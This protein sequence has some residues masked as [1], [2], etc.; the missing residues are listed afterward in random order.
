MNSSFRLSGRLYTLF[1]SIALT[2]VLSLISL[3]GVASKPGYHDDIDRSVAAWHMDADV[4]AAAPEPRALQTKNDYAI[5]RQ[6]HEALAAVAYSQA[7]ITTVTRIGYGTK[8]RGVASL[9]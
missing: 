8:Y 2:V 7:V 1:A 4:L 5:Q 9:T 6:R 3:P